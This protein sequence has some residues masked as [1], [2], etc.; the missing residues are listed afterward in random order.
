MYMF[1]TRRRETHGKGFFFV[2]HLILATTK[3]THKLTVANE[4][5]VQWEGGGGNFFHAPMKKRTANYFFAE[6]FFDVRRGKNT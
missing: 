1:A 4:G 3:A 6:H 5:N 2:M